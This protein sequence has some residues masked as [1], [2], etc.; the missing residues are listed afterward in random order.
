MISSQTSPL[1]S[2]HRIS[3]LTRRKHVLKITP[4]ERAA[5]ELITEGTS[6]SELAARLDISECELDSRLA[7]LFGRMGVK[8]ELEAAA[9]CVKR[10]L[11]PLAKPHSAPSPDSLT[12]RSAIAAAIGPTRTRTSHPTLPRR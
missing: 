1:L 6:R 11:C 10:G 8:T 3:R 5:L 9:E 4:E 7:A 2:R 12:P